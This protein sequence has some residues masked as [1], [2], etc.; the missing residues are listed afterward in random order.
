M[1]VIIADK[2]TEVDLPLLK[3]EDTDDLFS[4]AS[5]SSQPSSSAAG[6][7]SSISGVK[8]LQHRSSVSGSGEIPRY[9]IDV[10]NETALEQVCEGEGLLLFTTLQRLKVISARIGLW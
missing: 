3:V 9:G 5:C 6:I 8:P 1:T 2:E 10:P 7:M 4:P